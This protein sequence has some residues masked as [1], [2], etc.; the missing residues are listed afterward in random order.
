MTASTKQFIGKLVSTLI[1]VAA[2]LVTAVT[3]SD[4]DWEH[5]VLPAVV[6]VLAV[7]GIHVTVPDDK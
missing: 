6:G 3:H 5:T 2:V 7:L 1:P 4:V